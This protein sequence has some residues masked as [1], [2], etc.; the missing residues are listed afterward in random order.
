VT[1][2]DTYRDRADR[3]TEF[4][5]ALC[6]ANDSWW[7]GRN[8]P[9]WVRDDSSPSAKLERG[10]WRTGKDPFDNLARVV[11]SKPP[12]GALSFRAKLHFHW[13]KK[14]ARLMTYADEF[15]QTAA[16]D[17]YLGY[18]RHHLQRLV[19]HTQLMVEVTQHVYIRYMHKKGLQ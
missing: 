13:L 16:R 9:F 2:Q 17:R 10:H 7:S 4:R 14:Y 1:L 3:A 19:Y 12:F 15:N 6:A 18:V 8:D 11:Q 5:K